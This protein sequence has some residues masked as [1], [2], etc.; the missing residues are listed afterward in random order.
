MIA[1]LALIFAL[2]PPAA[3][4]GAQPLA[5]DPDEVLARYA[6]ALENAPTPK[7]AV[8]EYA[9]EQ[10][11]L[12]DFIQ[13]HRVYRA[14]RDERD[15]TLA[16]SGKSISPPLVRIFHKRID[17]Y[18]ISRLAPTPERYTFAFVGTRKTGKH[19]DY[20]YRTLRHTPAAFEVTSVTID[21]LRFLPASISFVTAQGRVHGSGTINFT[22][23]DR[24]W[25][26]VLA[27]AVANVAE[28]HARE[29]IAFTGYRFPISLPRS[30][31]SVPKPLASETPAPLASATPAPPAR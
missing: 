23:S 5:L 19:L 30:T 20:I 21:G 13:T 14:G 15:E 18:A 7:L 12:H 29:R 1:L 17:R 8:F 9:I 22:K 2:L 11:G 4:G 3:F 16:V 24:Y 31:F 27:V 28:D 26:P 10:A 25:V 6:S